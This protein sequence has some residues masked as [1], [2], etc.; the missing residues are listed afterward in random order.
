MP[1]L[2]D[3][4]DKQRQVLD[5]LAQHKTS[6][7]I[8]RDLDVAQNT[9]DKHLAAVRRKWGTADRYD[10][11][12]LF[13]QL[14]SDGWENHPP[15]ISADD[16]TV[17]APPLPAP[18]LPTSSTFRL[19]DALTIEDFAEWESATPKGLQALDDRFGKAW[20][21]AAI[22]AV[23]LAALMVMICAVA[24]AKVLTELF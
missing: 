2:D 19:S 20:R 1:S 24:L 3:L 14:R 6:K 22:P 4:T 15:R 13:G 9:I 21:V 11:V 12:R 16:A 17:P 7:E 10:T 23:A 18:D 8:A 5:Q